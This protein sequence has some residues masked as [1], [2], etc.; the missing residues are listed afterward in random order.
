MTT[1]S[2]TMSPG[3]WHMLMAHFCHECM[4]P[5]NAVQNAVE[6]LE[7]SGQLDHE[8]LGL[9][10]ASNEKLSLRLQYYRQAYGT[11]RHEGSS[12]APDK[13]AKLGVDLFNLQ[14]IVLQPTSLVTLWQT[15]PNAMQQRVLLN[16]MLTIAG[17]APMGGQLAVT[18]SAQTISFILES[19]KIIVSDILQILVDQG[20][21]SVTE[22]QL[23]PQ[24]IQDYYSFM[25][26]HNLPGKLKFSK[27]SD[28]TLQFNLHF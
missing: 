7:D 27:L 23:A 16:M 20:V 28:T 6:L 17:C 14:K 22:S 8:L 11:A 9:L 21:T 13:L 25:L 4:T 15:Y 3:A 24:T 10:K 1:M 5:V 19:A 18:T 2:P 26:L 12:M